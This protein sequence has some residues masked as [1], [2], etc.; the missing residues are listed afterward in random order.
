MYVAADGSDSLTKVLMYLDE[1]IA[2]ANSSRYM[3]DVMLEDS[4]VDVFGMFHPGA[5]GTITTYEARK[6]EV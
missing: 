1:A 2:A 3:A 5:K 6:N 4:L